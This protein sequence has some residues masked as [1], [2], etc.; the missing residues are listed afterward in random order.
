MRD[1][2]IHLQKCSPGPF[3]LSGKKAN[4]L[5]RICFSPFASLLDEG[6][7]SPVDGQCTIQSAT[8]LLDSYIVWTLFVMINLRI[9]KRRLLI[10]Y[11]NSVHF[12]PVHPSC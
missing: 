9:I 11:R 7:A 6:K 2:I 1:E 4:S 3:V 5:S 10:T 8:V 12:M